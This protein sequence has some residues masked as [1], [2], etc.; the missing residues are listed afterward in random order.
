MDTRVYV[1]SDHNNFQKL[2]HCNKN[3]PEK[4]TFSFQETNNKSCDNSN[5]INATVTLRNLRFENP[6]PI[7]IG[8]LNINS[9]RNKFEMVTSLITNEIDALY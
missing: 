1:S 7:M 3:Q 6:S 8:Q 9:I 5:I 4:S 2:N